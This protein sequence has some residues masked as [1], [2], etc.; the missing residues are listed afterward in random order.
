MRAMPMRGAKRRRR[1]DDPQGGPFE[2]AFDA[3]PTGLAL[4]DA[5]KTMADAAP[6]AADN[7]MAPNADPPMIDIW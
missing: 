7:V 1:I 6:G 2:T 5:D 4:L 3:S